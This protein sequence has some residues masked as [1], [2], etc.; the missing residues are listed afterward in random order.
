MFCNKENVNILTSQLVAYGVRHAVVCPGSRNAPIVHNLCEHEQ[1]CCYSVTDE[2]CAG[3]YALGICLSTNSPVVVCVTSGSALMNVAPAIVEAMYQHLPIIVISA[4]RAPQWIGQQDGQTMPQPMAVSQFV[5]HSVSLP[6]PSDDE[7]RWYCRRLVSECLIAS[8]KGCGG[9]VHINVPISEPLFDFSVEKLPEPQV[10]S[11]IEPDANI[12][13]GCEFFLQLKEAKRP[14]MIIG[15]A[16]NEYFIEED[17][18]ELASKMVVL[19][20]P[21]STLYNNRCLVDLAVKDLSGIEEYEPD[22]VFYVGDA[23]VSKHLKHFLRQCSSCREWIVNADGTLYDTF[24][25]LAGIVKAHPV[26]I[27]SQM[28]EAVKTKNLGKETEQYIRL[29]HT[30][31]QECIDHIDTCQPEFSQL[32]AVR[33]FEQHIDSLQQPCVVH[34][35]NSMAVRLASLY[36]RHFVYCNRG[37]NGIEGSLSVACGNAVATTKRV[38]CVIGDLS[39]FYDSNALWQS[40]LKGNLRILLLNNG[41]GGI[42][43]KLKGLETSAAR[44]D[45]VAASHGADARGVCL[46]NNISY[47]SANSD[48]ELEQQLDK[49]VN[50]DSDTPMLLEVFTDADRDIKE[51]NQVLKLTGLKVVR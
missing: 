40:Q 24:T 38:F 43:R 47:I 13:A 17:V 15:Q 51:Y 14:M 19:Q 6:E 3:F 18:A 45:F 25:H 50:A 21:L 9:P 28:A 48:E 27:I 30:R 36:S 11:L 41:G 39:F 42:F 1:V 46:Q 5:R 26:S 22:F 16:V 20:E 4:D 32:S 10:V 34:Y 12:D 7:E 31:F 37:V 2:R 8:R 23:I 29:W 49:L 33:R 44:K 35:S